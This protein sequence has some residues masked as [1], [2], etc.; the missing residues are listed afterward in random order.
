MPKR[1]RSETV[2]T[3][4]MSTKVTLYPRLIPNV[5]VRLLEKQ[6]LDVLEN[7]SAVE[8][9]EDNGMLDSV[10]VAKVLKVGRDGF[11]VDNTGCDFAKPFRK[12][13]IEKWKEAGA[14]PG[15]VSIIKAGQRQNC[16]QIIFS[17]SG[18]IPEPR[19]ATKLRKMGRK[20]PRDKTVRKMLTSLVF[21]HK[22]LWPIEQLANVLNPCLKET[23]SKK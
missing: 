17:S 7:L 6:D 10:T 12:M 9:P 2:A 3:R 15:L 19:K 4:P 5:D 13:I 18:M 1:P 22:D 23:L 14:G 11:L 21:M 16:K 20:K 8:H